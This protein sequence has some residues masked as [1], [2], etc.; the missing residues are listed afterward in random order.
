MKGNL[1]SHYKEEIKVL[2]QLYPDFREAQ[3]LVTSL[4]QARSKYLTKHHES[5]K[6]KASLPTK[7]EVKESLLSSRSLH[8]KGEIDASY[9][10][11]FLKSME[12]GMKGKNPA[13]KKEFPA[14][15]SIM[16]DKLRDQESPTCRDIF[17]SLESIVSASPFEKDLVTF[18][19][20][21]S[22]A[23]LYQAYYRDFLTTIDTSLWDG[24][25]CPVCA[26]KPHYGMLDSQEGSKVLEC[27]LCA[28]RWNFPRIKCPFCGN[29]KQK[30][31]S[32]FTR[33][34]RETICRVDLCEVCNS[35]Y[36]IF[37]IREYQ[38]DDADL[39]LHN[40]ATL[41][42]DI[43]ARR[44]GLLPGS[45]LEWLNEEELQTFER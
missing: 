40:L 22:L 29:E 8:L 9:F 13:M 20:T 34:D 43:M 11:L 14:F 39:A 41:S 32:Y 33:D 19:L 44:E 17:S 2:G 25:Y 1:D 26:Q 3:D 36:K 16:E 45:E 21:F 18:I 5:M 10:L 7:E 27:W 23:S 42:Y 30:K 4:Y 6:I 24:G 28:T 35:Y 31:L 38:Q 12:R 15:L 37:D